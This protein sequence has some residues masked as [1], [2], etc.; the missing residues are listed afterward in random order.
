MPRSTS[1]P[2]SLFHLISIIIIHT[3]IS[4]ALT[5]SALF[6]SFSTHSHCIPYV[7]IRRGRGRH[8]SSHHSSSFISSSIHYSSSSI[9]SS[10]E[11]NHHPITHHLSYH[12]HSITLFI[13]H[14]I[15]RCRESFIIPYHP[16]YYYYI[17]TSYRPHF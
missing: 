17:Y 3:V 6:H 10:G 12:L 5:L 2:S 16:S 13:F 7:G 1:Y 15:F 8:L 11:G 4:S 9:S 14:I